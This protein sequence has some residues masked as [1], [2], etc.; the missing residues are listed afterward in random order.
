MGKLVRK[1]S[2]ASPAKSVSYYDIRNDIIL[3]LESLEIKLS[4]EQSLR[5]EREAFE[6]QKKEVKFECESTAIII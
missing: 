2:K 6:Q 5:L 1:S 4:H 3:I